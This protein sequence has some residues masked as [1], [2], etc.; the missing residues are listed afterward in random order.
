MFD[1]VIPCSPKDNDNLKQTLRSLR[2]LRG[3]RS[4]YIIS[5]EPVSLDTGVPYKEVRDSAFDSL[6]T[7]ARIKARWLQE[8][9]DMAY[10]SSWVYQQL[11][12]LYCPQVIPD[13]LDSF[14]FLDSDTMVLRDLNLDPA[15]FQYSIPSENHTPYKEN[16]YRLTGLTAQSFSFINHH[17]MYRRLYLQEIF[18]HVHRC[19]WKPFFDV[20]LDSLDYTIQ[21]TMAEQEIYGNWM[22]FHH[23]DICEY[24][25][26]NTS[27]LNYIPSDSQL[28]DLAQQYDL[29][30]SHAWLRGIENRS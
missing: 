20:L 9:P 30:S 26:L 5:P 17:M 15:K 23:R 7:L 16:Y 8:F 13:L 14:L 19:H 11:L 1:V 3:W 4:I 28:T 6:F 21:S 25:H 10:R 22:Y 29:V 24:R 12:K 27:D 2:N 18:D